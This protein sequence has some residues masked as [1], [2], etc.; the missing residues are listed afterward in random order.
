MIACPRPV[1][2]L[3]RSNDGAREVIAT[4]TPEEGESDEKFSLIGP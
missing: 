2:D 1:P 3:M 4:S